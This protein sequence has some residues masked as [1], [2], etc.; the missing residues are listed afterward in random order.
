MSSEDLVVE[1]VLGGEAERAR[2]DPQI[3][4]L[5][6]Q[7]HVATWVVAREVHD[8]RDDLV[9]GLAAGERGRQRCR[10]RLG[11]QVQPS[12][13]GVA[14]FLRQRD[15]LHDRLVAGTGEPAHQLVEKA[16]RL[17]RVARNLGDALLVVVELFEREDRQVDVV[18]FEAEQARRVVHQDVG[19]E[20]EEL[21]GGRVS[22]LGGLAGGEEMQ[23]GRCRAE[24]AFDHGP[25]GVSERTGARSFSAGI[26]GNTRC[27]GGK[28]SE[29]EGFVV[30]T[31]H[32]PRPHLTGS[33]SRSRAT[34]CGCVSPSG[35]RPTK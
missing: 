28:P 16:R 35:V 33:F 9:V 34:C 18:L 3:D 27:C 5:G 2:L 30:R 31:G 19:V 14:G 1:V 8:D 25:P 22:R 17:P 15:T 20:H 13:R 21:A 4:V 11:L 32:H 7:D 23:R 24:L 26:H 6:D 29:T 10:D 12:R